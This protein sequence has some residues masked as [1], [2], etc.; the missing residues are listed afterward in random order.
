MQEKFKRKATT[1]GSSIGFTIPKF[2]F[3]SGRIQKG[4]EYTIIVSDEVT[5]ENGR[6]Q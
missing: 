3:N 1:V 5:V 2:L 6:L 4:K